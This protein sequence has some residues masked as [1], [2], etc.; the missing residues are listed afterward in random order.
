MNAATPPQMNSPSPARLMSLDVFRG[1]TIASM[2]LVNNPGNWGALYKPLDHAEWHGWTF[3]DLIFPFFIW[4][5]GVAIPLSTARRLEQGQSL[6]QL[7]LHALRRAAIIFALGFFLN[8]FLYLID[9]SLFRDGF[10]AWFHSYATT[11][12]VPGVLQRIGICYF[13][14]TM[15]YL[16]TGIRGQIIWIAGLLAGYWVLMVVGPLLGCGTGGL[17]QNGNF[18][19]YIDNLVLNGKIIGTHVWKGGKTWDPEGIFSTIPAIATCLFGIMTGHLI[20]SK[21]TPETKTAWLFVG[22]NLLL[23]AGV[24]MDVWLPINKKLW[25]SSYSVFMAGL[26]MNCFAVCYWLVDVQGWRKWAKPFA[27]YGMNAIAVFMMAGLLGRILPTIKVATAAGKTAGLQSYLYET[28][29][30]PFATPDTAPFF[31]FLASPKNASLMW[32]LMYVTGL[33]LVAY[34]MYRRKWFLKF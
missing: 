25:T 18:S 9:G 13:I 22:G 17:E 29:F 6:R 23:F 2:I 19:E 1:A 8:S 30:A 3:T 28:F 32:A 16:S 26:A 10:S 34:A 31:S 11:V 27:I 12:R 21:Q 24:V 5:V 14:A 15:I 4:I 7:L 33:Y 20:R